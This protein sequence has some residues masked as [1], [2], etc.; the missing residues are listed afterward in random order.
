MSA[1][2]PSTHKPRLSAVLTGSVFLLLW[3][4][5]WALTADLP[6][7]AAAY[8]RFIL[9]LLFISTGF[10][11]VKNVLLPKRPVDAEAVAEAGAEAVAETSLSSAESVAGVSTKRLVVFIAGAVLYATLIPFIGF[12]VTTTIFLVVSLKFFTD[13]KA[14]G[15]AVVAVLPF[16]LQW[17]TATGLGVTLPEGFWR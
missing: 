17:V 4:G 9:T 6:A 16:V 1:V 2:A 11:L 5:V 10:F 3:A 13:V 15:L 7:E 14:V 8:P 12:D